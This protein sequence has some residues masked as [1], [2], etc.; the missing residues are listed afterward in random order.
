ME[1]V[2]K[3][4]S[5]K[6]LSVMLVGN[7]PIDLN[8]VYD[9]LKNARGINYLAEVIFDTKQAFKKALKTRPNFIL[10]DDNLGRKELKKLLSTLKD[11]S[12]TREIP[13]TIIQNSN[14]DDISR[15]GAE[16]FILKHQV[17]SDSIARTLSNSKRFSRMQAYLR[18]A[19]RK[20]KQIFGAAK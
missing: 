10:I 7:N 1:V 18:L 8:N 14:R 9:S 12:R 3:N 20:R 6:P 19:S 5:K 17:D 13:I 11:N 4:S 2:A 16:E 15:E